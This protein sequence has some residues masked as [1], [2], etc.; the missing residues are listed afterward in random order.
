M[1]LFESTSSKKEMDFFEWQDSIDA[2]YNP[3]AFARKE[4]QAHYYEDN[5]LNSGPSTQVFT[6]AEKANKDELFTN[7]PVEKE[8]AS[9]GY[10]G[11]QNVKRRSGHSYDKDIPQADPHTEV[12]ISAEDAAVIKDAERRLGR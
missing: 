3:E 7:V 12:A 2:R 6:K 8:T 11:L 10:R 1:K 4:K 9:S 5:N